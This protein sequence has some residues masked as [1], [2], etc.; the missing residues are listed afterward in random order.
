MFFC[1]SDPIIPVSQTTSL[2]AHRPQEEAW[3]QGESQ[4]RGSWETRL[5]GLCSPKLRG[6]QGPNCVRLGGGGVQSDKGTLFSSLRALPC[7]S[8]CHSATLRPM[9]C[10]C[11]GV[12][13]HFSRLTYRWRMALCS[14]A[15]PAGVMPPALSCDPCSHSHLQLCALGMG[16]RWLEA[17]VARRL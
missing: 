17:S 5:V 15:E 2:A 14:Q 1:K 16:I 4:V 3:G 6:F 10:A 11:R 7:T 8:L 13:W 12:P 9:R